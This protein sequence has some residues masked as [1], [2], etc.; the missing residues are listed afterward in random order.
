MA[1]DSAFPEIEWKK[2]CVEGKQI[3]IF[4]CCLPE[5]S[6]ADVLFQELVKIS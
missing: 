2:F 6:Q 3:V 4:K 5:L 1:G